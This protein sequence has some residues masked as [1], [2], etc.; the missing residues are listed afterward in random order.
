M[1]DV[2]KDLMKITHFF[3]CLWFKLTAISAQTDKIL[4]SDELPDNLLNLDG[5]YVDS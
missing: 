3:C 5:V 1:K 2:Q 4:S